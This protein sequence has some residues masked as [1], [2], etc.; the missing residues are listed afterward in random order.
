MAI[1]NPARHKCHLHMATPHGIGSANSTPLGF[2]VTRKTR[3]CQRNSAAPFP[4]RVA[5]IILSR[6]GWAR[7]LKLPFQ[8][9]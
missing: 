8:G 3:F 4:E 5:R 2:K 7:G 6:P 9:T 1:K